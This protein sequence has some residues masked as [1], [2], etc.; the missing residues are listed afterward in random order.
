MAKYLLEFHNAKP[1]RETLIQAAS[2]GSI[3]L[4]RIMRERLPEAET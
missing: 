1:A 4:I 3:E 2:V